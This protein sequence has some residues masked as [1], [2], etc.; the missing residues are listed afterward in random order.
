RALENIRAVLVAAGADMRDVVKVGVFL[1]NIADAKAM[2]EVY[3]EF[4]ASNPPA[5]TTV[6]AALPGGAL[7]EIDAVALLPG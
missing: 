2:N 6:G 7:V 3:A 5:R 4:F 1:A